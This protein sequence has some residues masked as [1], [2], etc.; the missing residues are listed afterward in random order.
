M[1]RKRV[2]IIAAA[3]ILVLLC[4]MGIVYFLAGNNKQQAAPTAQPVTITTNPDTGEQTVNDPSLSKTESQDATNV[5]LYGLPDLIDDT[6]MY[7]Q[8]VDFIKQ[9]LYTYS[10]HNLQDKYDSLTVRPQDTKVKGDTVTSTIRLGEGDTLVNLQINGLTSG[11]MQVIITDPTGKNGGN[12]S[13]Q[14][15]TVYGD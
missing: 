10:N 14:I 1:N 12:Y 5:L 7:Q 4:L 6:N 15:Q 13:S 9:Q 8:Q 11:Q 3:I 2:V